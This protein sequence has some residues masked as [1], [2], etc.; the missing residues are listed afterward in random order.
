MVLLFV[1]IFLNSFPISRAVGAIYQSAR[2]NAIIRVN[3]MKKLNQNKIIFKGA[4]V[5]Y[6]AVE[7]ILI[8]TPFKGGPNCWNEADWIVMLSPLGMCAISII[9]TILI[10]FVI[11]VILVM[12][13]ECLN[14]A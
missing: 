10:L 2:E 6:D 14:Y 1:I 12:I 4:C 3:Y 7:E 8:A 5:R 11:L 9:Y 13:K